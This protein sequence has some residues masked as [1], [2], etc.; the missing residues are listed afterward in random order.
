MITFT[1]PVAPDVLLRPVAAGDAPALLRAAVRNREH[2]RPWDPHR[3]EEYFTLD[4]QQSRLADQLAQT[5]EGRTARWVLERDGEIAGAVG[6]TGIAAGHLRSAVLGY[7]IDAEQVGRG[8]A[9]AAVRLVCRAADEELGLHRL[10]AGAAVANTGSQRVLAKAG[11]ERIGVARGLLFLDGQW[12]DH[13]L[14]QLL[15]NDRRP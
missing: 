10:E 8:L 14:H 12:C 7:W 5:E 9:T 11:F 15:L 1:G 13:V 4:G 3:D 2:L 6:L